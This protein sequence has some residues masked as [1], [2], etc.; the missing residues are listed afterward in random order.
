MDFYQT[1]AMANN[2]EK[3]KLLLQ[4]PILIEIVLKYKTALKW[5]KFCKYGNTTT[6]AHIQYGG[7]SNKNP[8]VKSIFY[9]MKTF[10]RELGIT[11]FN[12]I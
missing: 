7:K 6:R 1:K 10:E 12:L 2:D 11:G 9:V 5:I 4:Y 8:H 3:N